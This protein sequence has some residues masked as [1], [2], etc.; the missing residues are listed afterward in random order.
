MYEQFACVHIDFMHVLVYIQC[1]IDYLLL[2]VTYFV[3]FVFWHL[4]YIW[5][6][7]YD[8]HF[9]IF[10][11]WIGFT[12]CTIFL[13]SINAFIKCSLLEI[14]SAVYLI[15]NSQH[16][17]FTISLKKR[18]LCMFVFILWKKKV[19]TQNNALHFFLFIS[20]DEHIF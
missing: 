19:S 8:F 16:R 3:L 4:H 7:W 20:L 9:H 14:D 15:K 13:V 18:A 12:I 2:F 1:I 17:I 5:M 11:S 10:L 6:D